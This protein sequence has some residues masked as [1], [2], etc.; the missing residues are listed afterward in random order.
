M[1]CC[2]FTNIFLTGLKELTSLRLR[3]WREVGKHLGLEECDLDYI[4]ARNSSKPHPCQRAMFGQWRKEAEKPTRKQMAHALFAS[5]NLKAAKQYC[6]THGNSIA[7]SE[8]FTMCVHTR[9][10]GSALCIP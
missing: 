3:A 8:I 2:T 9:T 1:R 10:C 7:T 5:G 4:E 6:Q